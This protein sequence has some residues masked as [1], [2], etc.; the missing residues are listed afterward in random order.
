[1]NNQ[2]EL[3]NCKK[4]GSYIPDGWRRCGRCGQPVSYTGF[5][6]KLS[7]IIT[8][9]IIVSIL[10][11]GASFF[12]QMFNNY[13]EELPIASETEGVISKEPN[14]RRQNIYYY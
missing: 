12:I 7:R 8:I 11:K 13:L 9:L 14:S 5:M 4:C 10:A 2:F 1:M 6:R 3:K